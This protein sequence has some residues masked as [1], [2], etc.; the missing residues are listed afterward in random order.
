MKRFLQWSVFGIPFL[1]FTLAV[2]IREFLLAKE[3]LFRIAG[4]E[5]PVRAALVMDHFEEAEEK[6]KEA[7]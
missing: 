2:T 3:L 6:K 4:E 5:S 7:P 1:D